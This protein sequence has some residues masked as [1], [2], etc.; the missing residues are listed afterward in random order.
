V[1]SELTQTGDRRFQVQ[2]WPEYVREQSHPEQGQYLFSYRIEIANHSSRRVQLMRRRWLITDG[3]GRVREVTGEG[4][5]G[6][7]PVLL[8]GQAYEY[9]SFS[10]L[11]TPT[12][13]MRGSYE[14]LDL[15]SGE[16]FQIRIP[17]F[18]LRVA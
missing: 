4:V 10:V 14:L 8:P 17:L 6:E 13:N 16:Q 11:P 18:F 15:D 12:G 3:Q 5:V 7:Q 1:Y 2:A 9:S